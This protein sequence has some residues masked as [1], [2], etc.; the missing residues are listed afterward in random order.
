VHGK[1][2]HMRWKIPAREDA[3]VDFGMQGLDTTVEHFRETCVIG[4]LGDFQTVFSQQPGRAACGE[5]S[6]V[7]RGQRSSELKHTGFIGDRN[8]RL[9]DHEGSIEI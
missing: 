2:L 4:D 5:Q 8:Q 3:A 6:D 9:S 7:Q 1:C